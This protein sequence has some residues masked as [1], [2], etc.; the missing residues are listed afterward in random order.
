MGR[1]V[2]TG[3]ERWF[4]LPGLA[5][6]DRSLGADMLKG[7]MWACLKVSGNTAVCKEGA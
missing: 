6:G 7:C 5:R 4:N 2:R 3:I 1:L